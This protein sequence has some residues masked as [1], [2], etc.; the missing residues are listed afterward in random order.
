MARDEMSFKD[1]KHRELINEVDGRRLGRVRDIIFSPHKGEVLG[2]IA[3][4]YHRVF[5]IF[6]GEQVYIPFKHIIKIGPD[7]ILVKLTP[8]LCRPDG[9]IDLKRGHKKEHLG[10]HEHHHHKRKAEKEDIEEKRG[11]KRSCD[12]RCE[13]CMMFDCEERWDDIK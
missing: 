12:K 7:V 9:C 6:K 1:L 8:D 3:P 11:N 10:H 13:K 4:F 5:P 2:L